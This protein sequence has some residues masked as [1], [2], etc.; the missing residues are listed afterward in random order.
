MEWGCGNLDNGA[1]VEKEE[2]VYRKLSNDLSWRDVVV[3]LEPYLTW[4]ILWIMSAGLWLFM[5]QNMIKNF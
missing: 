2:E 3:A 5:C 1:L 4:C